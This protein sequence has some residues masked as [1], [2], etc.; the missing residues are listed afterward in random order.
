MGV[1]SCWDYRMFTTA[2]HVIA[3]YRIQAGRAYMELQ[4]QVSEIV[5]RN[6][7]AEYVPKWDSPPWVVEIDTAEILWDLQIQ[8]DYDPVRK[9]FLSKTIG[10]L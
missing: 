10:F 1:Q 7:C 4:I 5:D 6:M 8:T 2:Q 3:K 9:S